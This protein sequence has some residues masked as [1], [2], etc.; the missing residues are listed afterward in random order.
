ML[1]FQEMPGFLIRRLH[2]I[3]VAIFLED[4]AAMDF[5]LTPVQFAALNA[6]EVHPGIDQATLAGLIA[7]DRV[8]LGG[9]VDR[10]VQKGLVVRSVNPQDRRARRL[11]LAPA[12]K[13]MLEAV[14][15]V[16]GKVQDRIL[17]GLDENERASLLALLKKAAGNANGMSRAPL[18]TGPAGQ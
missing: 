15:P 13:A 1:D 11:H 9:V 18:R 12:G 8:T 17:C 3:S 6:L 4:L 16:V 2:Q 14:L 7:H 5:D 10:L